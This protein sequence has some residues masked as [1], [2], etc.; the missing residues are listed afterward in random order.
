MW[1][2]TFWTRSGS[3]CEQGVVVV[4][5]SGEDSFFATTNMSR[6]LNTPPQFRPVYVPGA[7]PAELV[8]RHRERLAAAGDDTFVR[9]DEEGLRSSILQMGQ[10]VTAY[11]RAR[12]VF[13]R[14]THDEVEQVKRANVYRT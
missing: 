3:C 5:R 4:S 9:L 1:A 7:E 14:M 2:T 12:G 13:R 11:H 6:K 8:H 10:C